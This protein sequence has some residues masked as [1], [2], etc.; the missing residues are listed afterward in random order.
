M[1]LDDWQRYV[2]DVGLALRSDESFAAREVALVVARQNGKGS[3]LEVLALTKCLVA[4][5]PLVLW[6][7]HEFA[8]ALE[9]YK[10][11][12]D[13]IESS[14]SLSNRVEKWY[15][16]ST[17]VGLDFKNGTRIRFK[18]RTTGSGRG[19]SASTLICDEAMF[20]NDAHMSALLP[21]ISANPNA[22]IWYTSSAALI[23]SSTLHDLRNRALT[24]TGDDL[25]YMEWSAPEDCDPEDRAA[26]AQANPA[27]GYRLSEKAIE[28]EFHA[29]SPQAFR[30]ERLS[31]PDTEAS[32]TV[33]TEDLWASCRDPRSELQ[34][35]LI[36][37]VD[38]PPDRSA[39]SIAVAGL[40][41]KQ[42]IHVEIIDNREGVSWVLPRL[43]ELTARW[44][45]GQLLLDPGSG[46]GSLLRDLSDLRIEP[47]MVSVREIG[48]AS[49]AFYDAVLEGR[50]A[51]R[52]Q[53]E[54]DRAVLSAERRPLGDAFA[55]KRSIDKDASPLIAATFA[56][57]G[58]QARKRS[59]VVSLAAALAEAESTPE[60]TNG[61]G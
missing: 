51:H 14:V 42:K 52:G 33:F 50:L 34:G 30:R 47:R 11:L 37:A 59:K 18:A 3:I 31:I 35:R 23:Q 38:I 56:F 46:S 12:K 29:M 8:T 2:V 55:W 41:G 22:Q 27:L 9:G 45:A 5:E 20:L 57:W 54:L 17:A 1:D 7:A 32:S 10:R 15:N 49:G 13:L 43:R 48:Q 19:W 24:K 40:N 39:A 44:R 58:V 28:T 25:A 60:D 4:H 26:W 36:F 6:T 16:S 53:D 21:T 61:N